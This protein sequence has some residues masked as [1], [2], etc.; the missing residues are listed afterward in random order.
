M[1]KYNGDFTAKECRAVI[2]YLSLKRISGTLCDKSRNNLLGLEYDV[3]ALNTKANLIYNS[4]GDS[5]NVDA[6]NS[7][8]LDDQRI[9]AKDT[10]ALGISRAKGCLSIAPISLLELGHVQRTLHKAA[11]HVTPSPH[12]TLPHSNAVYIS[13]SIRLELH[14]SITQL[15][16]QR[17]ATE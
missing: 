15:S 17:V 16:G 12:G 10:E 2:R 11:G 14:H 8:I 5:R 13:S 9:S 6:I 7:R 4:S 1:A 3:S